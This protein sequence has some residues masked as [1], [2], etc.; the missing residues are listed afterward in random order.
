LDSIG[1][2]SNTDGEIEEQYSFDVYGKP[3]TTSSIGNPYLFTGRRLDDESN[4]YYYRAR[5]YSYELGRFLQT[6]P[7]GY[8]DSMNLYSYVG[9]NPINWIDPF[10]LVSHITLDDKGNVSI[11]LP[12]VYQGPGASKS[13]IRKFNKGIEKHWTG[14]FGKYNVTTKVITPAEDEATNTVKILRGW[15]DKKSAKSRLGGPEGYWPAKIPGYV[16]AH[17]AGH[18]MGEID[19]STIVD[20]KNVPLPDWE[21]NIMAEP[22]PSP[23]EIYKG[24]VD[25]RNIIEIL[26][27]YGLYKEEKK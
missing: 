23:G 10:G 8:A 9:N 1:A 15:G 12:M 27:F 7:I 5:C 19:Y 18:L 2:L 22:V 4:L 26:K 13:V 20:G 17:E 6:D 11:L 21:G 24:K 16:A 3:D 14:K 25:E